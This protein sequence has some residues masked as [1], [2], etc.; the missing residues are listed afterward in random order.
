M[1]K[2]TDKK[3]ISQFETQTLPFDMWTHRVHVRI[4]YIYADSYD[5][6]QA[7]VKLRS[8][9]QE[10]NKANNVVESQYSGYNETTTVAFFRLIKSTIEAYNSVYP[11][12]DSEDFCK[13][14][15]HLLTKTVLRFFY[16]PERRS[17]PEAKTRFVKPD[18]CQLP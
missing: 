11:T 1:Q 16:S 6:E 8:G 7:L 2:M 15:P 14:H 12:S 17:H 10:Y 4:A 5:Y 18:L 3:L 9:I 13:T